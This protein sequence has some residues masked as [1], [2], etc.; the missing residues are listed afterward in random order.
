MCNSFEAQKTSMF[1]PR[2]YREGFYSSLTMLAR[3]ACSLR[4]KPPALLRGI[5]GC[6]GATPVFIAAWFGNAQMV[7]VLLAMRA[8]PNIPNRRGSEEHSYT[9]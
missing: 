7:N 5:A 9:V 4:A 3:A 1:L 8:D 2:N 6:N